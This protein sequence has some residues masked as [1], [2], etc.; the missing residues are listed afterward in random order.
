MSIIAELGEYLCP[1]GNGVFTVSTA[2]DKKSALHR[3]LY[4]SDDLD[5]LKK[6]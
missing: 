1:A 5:F 6:G 4:Q 3:H 2:S